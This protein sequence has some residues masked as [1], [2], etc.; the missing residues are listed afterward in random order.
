MSKSSFKVSLVK[1]LVLLGFTFCINPRS[2]MPQQSA[3]TGNDLSEAEIKRIINTF[4]NKEKEFRSALNK[5]SFRRDA[6]LQSV[7]MGGQ[8]TGEFHRVS[9]FTFDDRGKRYEKITIAPMST[10]PNV[11]QEDIDDLGGINPFALEPDKIDQYNFKYMG[12][13]RIDELDLFVFDVTPK[14]MPDASKTKER[15]F[16]GRVWVDDHDLQIVK[17]RGKG[18]PETKNNKY[19]YV[20]TYREEIGGRYWFP[21]YSY[22]DEELV[23]DSGEPLHVRMK[24]RYSDFVPAHVTVNIREADDQAAAAATDAT[25]APTPVAT[26]TPKPLDLSQPIESGNLNSK[27]IELPDPVLPQGAP[28]YG[29]KVRVRVI[30]DETGKV[31]SAEIE[32][33]RIELRRPA[34]EAARKARFKPSLIEGKPVQITGLL[35][36]LFVQ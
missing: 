4:T 32:D 15:L 8:V 9:Y 31:I 13:E 27:A 5:F 33:G 21:T 35:S 23:F 19:P 20:E 12:K 18:V 17:T 11:T 3:L 22:A 26:P 29:G 34:L 16:L 36:Y 24:V 25:P 30:V 1:I 10:L 7:G 2:V 28:K 14:V 6:T